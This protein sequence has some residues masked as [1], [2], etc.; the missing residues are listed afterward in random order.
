MPLYSS[1]TAE[2]SSD[3]DSSGESSE[4]ADSSDDDSVKEKKSSAGVLGGKGV[5]NHHI[6]GLMIEDDDDDE[7]LVDGAHVA[8][9]MSTDLMKPLVVDEDEEEEEEQEDDVVEEEEEEDFGSNDG[10]NSSIGSASDLQ[11][12]DDDDDDEDED[13]DDDHDEDAD[14]SGSS[15]S[16]CGNCSNSSFEGVVAPVSKDNH[17]VDSASEVVAGKLKS[18]KLQADKPSTTATASSS[19]ESRDGFV[20]V[21][22]DGSSSKGHPTNWIKYAGGEVVKPGQQISR[23]TVTTSTEGSSEAKAADSKSAEELKSCGGVL[24]TTT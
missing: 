8:Q 14:D 18:L 22:Y 20:F 6:N 21:N 23:I 19:Q 15:S 3:L 4:E 9:E 12:T 16:S 1:D 17:S 5:G 7:E 11:A 24:G 2:D 10:G 13:E